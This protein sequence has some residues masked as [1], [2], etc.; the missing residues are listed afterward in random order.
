MILR[1]LAYL[2]RDL[3]DAVTDAALVGIVRIEEVTRWGE[4][5]RV[6]NEEELWT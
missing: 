3:A 5:Q 1:G 4:T 2:S 6:E